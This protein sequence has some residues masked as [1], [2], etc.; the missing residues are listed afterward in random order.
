MKGDKNEH[1]NG[2]VTFPE[3]YPVTLMLIVFNHIA[4]RKARIVYNFGLSECNI[5]NYKMVFSSLEIPPQ[6]PIS[7]LTE[8]H[9]I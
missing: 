3:S 8:N 4:L 7:A 5:V 2:R 9:I 6:I 1:E